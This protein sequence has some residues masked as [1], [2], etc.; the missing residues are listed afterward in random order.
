MAYLH[1][2][3]AKNKEQKTLQ[4]DNVNGAVLLQ[5]GFKI[6]PLICLIIIITD[7]KYG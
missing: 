7:C 1:V 6:D 3:L 5:Q 2:A 4:S